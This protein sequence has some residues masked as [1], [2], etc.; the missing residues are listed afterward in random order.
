MFQRRIEKKVAVLKTSRLKPSESTEEAKND[1][2]IIK[3]RK[4]RPSH[5]LALVASSVTNIQHT[6]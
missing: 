1:I 2:S 4:S 5:F 6:S 3:S